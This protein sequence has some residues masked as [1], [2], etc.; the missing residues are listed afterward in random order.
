MACQLVAAKT[1]FE[2]LSLEVYSDSYEAC[3]H[4]IA[5]IVWCRFANVAMG[6][7]CQSMHPT[8]SDTIAQHLHC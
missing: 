4:N 2:S 7:R 1:Q 3:L 5:G 6:S 8:G